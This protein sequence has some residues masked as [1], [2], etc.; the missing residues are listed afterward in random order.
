M[1]KDPY[2]RSNVLGAVIAMIF[3]IGFAFVEVSHAQ[4][5]APVIASR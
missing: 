1:R 2:A 3:A 4:G 5:P